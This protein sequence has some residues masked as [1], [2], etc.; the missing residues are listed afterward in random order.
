M[1]RREY[2]LLYNLMVNRKLTFSRERLPISVWGY[3][4]E[5]GNRT[6][7]PHIRQLRGKLGDWPTIS[8]P[9]IA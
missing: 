6:V 8:K 2:A 3:D 7:D 9:Y 1:T 5:A 4:F